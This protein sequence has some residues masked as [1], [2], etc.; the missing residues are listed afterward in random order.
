M[1]INHRVNFF[2]IPIFL[3]RISLLLKPTTIGASVISQRKGDEIRLFYCGVDLK[4]FIIYRKRE[5]LHIWNWGFT[6][7]A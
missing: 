5:G 3:L 1:Y 6:V 2:V 7:A 4:K